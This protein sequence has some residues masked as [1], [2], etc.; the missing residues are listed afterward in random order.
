MLAGY[1][2]THYMDVLRYI[3]NDPLTSVSSDYFLVLIETRQKMKPCH[4][5]KT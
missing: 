3:W 5:L 2:T 1:L 4:M